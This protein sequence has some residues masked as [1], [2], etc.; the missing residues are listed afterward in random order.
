MTV[1]GTRPYP[2]DVESSGS[3]VKSRRTGFIIGVL[4]DEG[5]SYEL[6]I[7]IHQDYHGA[8]VGSHLLPATLTYGK[9]RGVEH[10]WL[11]VERGNRLAVNLYND[12]GFTVINEGYDIEMALTL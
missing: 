8:G 4:P 1:P 12:V 5:K 9:Q 10:V 11:L 7:F 2:S 3:E 6:A